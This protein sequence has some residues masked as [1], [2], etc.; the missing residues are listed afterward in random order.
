MAPSRPRPQEIVNDEKTSLLRRPLAAWPTWARGALL[1]LLALYAALGATIANTRQHRSSE[2]SHDLGF[3]YGVLIE[4][5]DRTG[6]YRVENIHYPGIAFSAHRLPLIPY[7]V[8]GVRAIVGDNL[9]RIA[10][11][12]IA[13]GTLA[14]ALAFRTLARYSTVPGWL[15]VVGIAYVLTMPRWALAFFELSV[16]EAYL[17]PLFGWLFAELWFTPPAARNQVAWALLIGLLAATLL[18]VKNSTLYWC[19][20]VPVLIWA[21]GQRRSAYL[22]LGCVLAGCV[23]LATFNLRHSGRFT[24][25]SSWEGWNLYKGNCVYT[26]DLY[27]PYSLDLL[28]Y[29]GKVV[30]DR[31]LR[32]EW[33]HNAYFKSKAIEFIRSHPAE[34]LNLALRKAWVF[35]GEVRPTGLQSRQEPRY[36]KPGTAFQIASMTVFRVLLWSAIGLALVN[37]IR[38]G[39]GEYRVVAAGY[40]I[41]LV[42]YSGF[43]VVGFAYERHIMPIV[44]PTVL[45]LLRNVAQ[46]IRLPSGGGRVAAASSHR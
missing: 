11:V 23:G 34:F 21:A 32:D 20:A 29:E 18:F 4:A 25:G 43:Y 3:G 39:H 44:L 42:L 15:V 26:A 9:A 6:Q 10:L 45:Y 2:T 8:I 7:F 5:I 36:G 17:I 14:L 28:D 35:Y 37:A 41:F 16:E 31:P 19:L 33:D 40:L 22:I 24:T 12:K 30:A 27:P 46:S 38:R 1:T 13:L